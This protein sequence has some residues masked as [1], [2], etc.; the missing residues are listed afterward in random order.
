MTT[1]SSPEF[2]QPGP[3]RPHR[4]VALCSEGPLERNTCATLVRAG[5][6]LVGVVWCARRGF[7]ART[8]FLR[9]WAARH[10]AVHTAGQILGRLYD[11]ARNGRR[12][13]RG[14]ARPGDRAGGPAT[15]VGAGPAP[16]PTEWCLPPGTPA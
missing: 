8:R 15:L 4:V 1:F 13:R 6:N 5:V 10:G 12:G 14:L 9:R 11:R 3:R 16:L 7:K 2:L